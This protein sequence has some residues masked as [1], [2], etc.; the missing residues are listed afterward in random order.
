MSKRGEINPITNCTDAALRTQIKGH[1]RKCW[2][3]SSRRVFIEKVRVVY[4]GAGR[5]KFGVVC[6]KCNRMMGQSEKER[7]L[8][9]SGK[10]AKRKSSCY[11]IDH[12][13]GITPFH[14]WADLGQ[15]AYDLLFGEQEILC[16][17]CHTAFTKKQKEESK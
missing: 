15:Y 10:L 4:T 7:K 11:E 8:L 16:V 1:L 9:V 2:R 14:T 3:N 17:G 13:H 5:F 12:V 6:V